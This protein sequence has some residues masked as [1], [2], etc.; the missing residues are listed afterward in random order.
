M[1][2]YG[3]CGGFMY[4]CNEVTDHEGATYPMTGCFPFSVKMLKKLKSLGYRDITLA[5]DSVIGKKGLTAKGHEFHYSEIVNDDGC[6]TTYT[7]LGK[8]NNKTSKE[9]YTAGNTLGSYIHLHFG[10]NP[11]IGEHFVDNCIKWRRAL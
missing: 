1:P 6:K 2:I 9:G 8:T 4:L 7:V 5:V 10:S 11:R 3:E